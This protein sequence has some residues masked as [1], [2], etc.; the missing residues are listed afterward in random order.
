MFWKIKY[1][2]FVNKCKFNIVEYLRE[3][4]QEVFI[5][6]GGDGMFVFQKVING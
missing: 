6:D 1:N 5:G 3:I 4:E 2:F